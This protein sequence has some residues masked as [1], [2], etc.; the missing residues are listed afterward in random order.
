MAPS[1]HS[2]KLLTS[3]DSNENTGGCESITQD[4]S[5]K[6]KTFENMKY[7]DDAT[8]SDKNITTSSTDISSLHGKQTFS[9][10]TSSSV[11]GETS[12]KSATCLRIQADEDSFDR[13]IRGGSVEV[14][15]SDGLSRNETRKRHSAGDLPA[16]RAL[17]LI[18]DDYNDED[19]DDYMNV[20]EFCVDSLKNDR[21]N[22]A[23][24]TINNA[25]TSSLQ[26][27]TKAGKAT[28]DSNRILPPSIGPLREAFEKRTVFGVPERGSEARG[29]LESPD[30][31]DMVRKNQYFPEADAGLTEAEQD[32]LIK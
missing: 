2:N 6:L 17:F 10:E 13:E 29:S 25:N 24:I 19:D 11:D 14:D 8:T 9:N 3:M 26:K 18:D 5:N 7:H 12:G 28:D 32:A 20:D 1:E 4:L 30:S 31:K 16:Y 27:R 15:K 23:N 21:S 22:V